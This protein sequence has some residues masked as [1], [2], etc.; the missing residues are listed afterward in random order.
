MMGHPNSRIAGERAFG[1]LIAFT[2]AL[3]ILACLSGCSDATGSGGSETVGTPIFD[4]ASG[5]VAAGSAISIVCPTPGAEIRYALRDAKLGSGSPVYSSPITVD[6]STEYFIIRA[7]ARCSGMKDS[8]IVEARYP[9]NPSIPSAPVFSEMEGSYSHDLSLYLT[10]PSE[11]AVVRYTT[12][13]VEMTPPDPDS[14]S[15]AF[16]PAAPIMVKGDGSSITIKAF[17]ERKGQRSIIVEAS[18]TVD[19]SRVSTPRFSIAS[20]SFA[21]D[22]SVIISCDTVDAAIFYTLDVTAEPADPSAGSLAYSPGTPILAAGNGTRL[23]L[24]AVASM[25]GMKPSTISFLDCSIAY[26]ALPAP[27]FSPPSGTFSAAQAVGI[28]CATE[29]AIIRYLWS[30]SSSPGDPSAS[31]PV[32]DTGSSIQMGGDGSTL[33]VAAYASKA[34]WSDSPVSSG[35][36]SVVFP[37]VDSPTFNKTA[38]TYN[39]DQAVTIA[40]ATPGAAIYY[41]TN[42]TAPSAANGTACS[43]GSSVSLATKTTLKA[44]AVLGGY[45]DSSIA[46]AAYDFKVAAPSFHGGSPAGIS[47]ATVIVE[48]STPGATICYTSSG[49]YNTYTSPATVVEE[50][51]ASIS[52]YATKP[53]YTKSDTQ[54]LDLKLYRPFD[55]VKV[56]GGQ[57]P[58]GDANDPAAS[59]VRRVTV[60]SFYM[61]ACPVTNEGFETSMRYRPLY[62][63]ISSTE[64]VVGAQWAE[65]AAFCNELSTAKGLEPVYAITGDSYS[66]FAVAAADFS[67]SGYRLPTEAEWEYAARGGLVA[68]N[69]LYPGSDDASDF[70]DAFDAFR[71]PVGTGVRNELGLYDMAGRRLEWCW[72]WYSAGYDPAATDNPMGPSAGSARVARGSS[73]QDTWLPYASTKRHAYAPSATANGWI[74]FRVVRRASTGAAPISMVGVQGGT[75]AMGSGTTDAFAR[76]HQVTLSSFSLSRYETT[77]SAWEAVMG[78]DARNG[79]YSGIFPACDLSVDDAVAFCNKLSDLYGFDRAYYTGGDGAVRVDYGKNGFRLPTEAEWE[80]AARGGAKSQGYR[81]AGSNDLAEV[82]FNTMPDGYVSGST[83]TGKMKPN[84]L[85]LFDMSGNAWEWVWDEWGEYPSGPVTDPRPVDSPF[86]YTIRLGFETYLLSN[87]YGTDVAARVPYGGLPRLD[88]GFRVARSVF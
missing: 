48:C 31:S 51:S 85:G 68:R 24:K 53:G 60:G 65:A 1:K 14:T 42:G 64:P 81:F 63:G 28:S 82:A 40:C 33:R 4:P 80:Y 15:P 20:G 43:S 5:T 21:T 75:F 37:T 25:D 83:D 62:A 67:K 39:S 79:G 30:L 7:Y 66:G 54:A 49:L 74:G 46:S 58:M 10:S 34:G 47:P 59:P 41:T 8:A 3:V 71:D 22:Q 57:F 84:E 44:I 87:Q 27:A 45:R 70:S 9:V 26:P 19:Y 17:S 13:A 23:R 88:F 86:T 78:P 11:G 16:D 18:Y 69:Y 72:D 55:E 2:A 61:S 73:D 38:G 77:W 36:F 50:W 76:S 29:G 6:D 35:N 52:A 56:D 32:F 12:A